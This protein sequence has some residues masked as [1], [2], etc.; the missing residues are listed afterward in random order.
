MLNGHP[1]LVVPPECGFAIWLKPDWYDVDWTDPEIRRTFAEAVQRC[2]KFE[3]WSIPTERLIE[4]LDAEVPKDYSDAVSRVYETFGRMRGKH[5]R[6]WGDKNN[7]YV[8]H[9]AEL[10]Q[11][12]PQARYIHIVRDVRDVACSYQELVAREIQSKYRPQLTTDPAAIA[13]EWV[14]NNQAV[15]DILEG[16]DRYHRMRYEDLVADVGRTL[17]SALVALEVEGFEP[18]T[19]EKRLKALDEPT[20]F[21]QW[22]EKLS[23]PVDT[24]SI[25]RYK[26]EMSKESIAVIEGICGPL[27]KRLGY[28]VSRRSL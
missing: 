2:R 21:L 8:A 13:S 6:D 27:L 3:T 12:F 9:V 4:E 23:G 1:D 18:L 20:E 22:K 16:I 26:K 24:S 28:E 14:R 5:I 19:P 17:K 15:M 25:G 11:L 7:Y 10:Q